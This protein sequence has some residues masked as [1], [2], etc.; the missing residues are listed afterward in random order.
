MSY[1]L[2]AEMITAFQAAAQDIHAG[3][4]CQRGEAARGVNLFAIVSISQADAMP[5]W[6]A[7]ALFSLGQHWNGTLGLSSMRASPGPA[8]VGRHWTAFGGHAPGA[9]PPVEAE[10]AYYAALKPS[11]MVG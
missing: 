8:R 1:A 4:F 9:R 10:A 11:A 6:L 3:T 5:G 7:H 2:P